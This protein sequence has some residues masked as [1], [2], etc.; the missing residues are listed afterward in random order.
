M[1]TARMVES[2]AAL[3][4]RGPVG[5]DFI[6]CDLPGASAQHFFVE[7]NPRANGSTYVCA[8]WEAVNVQRRA[9][10]LS[11]LGV[12]TSIKNDHN[13]CRSFSELYAR[14]AE[15]IYTHDRGRG[16][17]PYNTTS[18]AH[19]SVSTVALAEDAPAARAV[20]EAFL[21]RING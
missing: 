7:V 11:R 18:L 12:C 15:L 6:E 8:I 21:R 1:S 10:G 14:A 19:H 5:L 16:I 20:E 2:L 17:V 9:R 4:V 13:P 3:G